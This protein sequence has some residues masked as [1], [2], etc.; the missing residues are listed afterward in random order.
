MLKKERILDEY[1]SY[2]A[3]EFGNFYIMEPFFRELYKVFPNANIKTTMQ[4]SERF[5]RDEKVQCVPM[6]L[7]YGWNE[8]DL[9]IALKELASAEIYA[10]TGTLPKETAYIKEVLWA[11]FSGD[12]WGDNADFL[13]SDRFL[14]GLIKDRVPQL[15]AGPFKNKRSI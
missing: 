11:D 9:D 8:K 1:F 10:K 4:M 5:Q 15:L 6:E 7:Y 13:G 14:V 12:I 2:W 3:M